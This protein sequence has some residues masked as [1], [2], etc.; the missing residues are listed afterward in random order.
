MKKTKLLMTAIFI[1]VSLIVSKAQT[2]DFEQLAQKLVF[3]CANIHE[4]ESVIVTGKSGDMELLEDLAINIRKKGAFPLIVVGSDRLTRRMY[5]DVPVKYDSQVSDFDL[6]LTG[7]ISA[8]IS[9]DYSENPALLADIPVERQLAIAKSNQKVSELFRDR[10]IK[11]VSLGN[12]LY[13][14]EATAKQYG[15]SLQELS[16]IFWN[17]V[18]VDYDQLEATGKKVKSTLLEGKVVEITNPNG[19]NLKMRIENKPVMVSDGTLSDEDLKGSYAD[20]LVYLPA[21]EVAQVTVPGTAEGKVVVDHAYIEGNDIEGLTLIFEKGR[22]TSMSALTGIEI[23]KKYY[24]A[25]E[26]GKEELSYFDIGINPNVVIKKGTKLVSWMPA[27]MVTIAIGGNAYM[28][29]ENNNL[30]GA[31][32]HLPGCTLKVDGMVLIDNGVLKK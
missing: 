17:G 1:M 21:G 16:E 20:A 28:G 10:K 31:A 12:G 18:N 6:K 3:Q 14:T 11:L 9:L 7:I 8:Q 4:G 24:D 15:L 13:P 19:T 32:F 23:F 25:A 2:I 26:S 5:T 27:G 29:G 22:L 30:F